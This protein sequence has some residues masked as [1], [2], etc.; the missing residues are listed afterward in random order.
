[1]VS[2]LIWPL[3]RDFSLLRDG[4]LFGDGGLQKELRPIMKHIFENAPAPQ[5]PDGGAFPDA[6]TADDFPEATW[7]TRALELEARTVLESGPSCWLAKGMLE[8]PGWPIV[9][10]LTQC[11]DAPV[12]SDRASARQ[13]LLAG[14]VSVN[15]EKIVDPEFRVTLK[16]LYREPRKTA[17]GPEASLYCGA[18]PRRGCASLQRTLRMYLDLVHGSAPARAKWCCDIRPYRRHRT[19]K[20]S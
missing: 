12:D 2:F 14:E 6:P 9:D 15:H 11:W 16:N 5:E 13:A 18:A 1:V 17:M 10:L 19:A 3:G 7:E 8:N 4:P 20:I